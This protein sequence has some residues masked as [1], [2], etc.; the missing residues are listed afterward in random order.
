MPRRLVL[1]ILRE[2]GPLTPETLYPMSA[3][4]LAQV[5]RQMDALGVTVEVVPIPLDTQRTTR[6]A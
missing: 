3:A 6:A 5:L 4:S 2:A 1:A